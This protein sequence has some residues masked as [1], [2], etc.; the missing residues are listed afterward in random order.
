MILVYCPKLVGYTVGKVG[1]LNYAR[2][3]AL[4][5]L[6]LNL[7]SLPCTA[8]LPVLLLVY[9]PT[10]Q[11]SI[12]VALLETVYSVKFKTLLAV[13]HITAFVRNVERER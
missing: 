9:C 1:P 11:C 13:K 10:S 5:F 8:R 7:V 6:L 4:S 2:V 3:V 12:P